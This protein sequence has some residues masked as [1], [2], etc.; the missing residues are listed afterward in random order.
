MVKVRVVVVVVAA[1]V[2]GSGV[3]ILVE[4]GAAT[5]KDGP[6]VDDARVAVWQI[7]SRHP[8][9]LIIAPLPLFSVLTDSHND[10]VRSFVLL[11]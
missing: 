9:F 6:V 1:I 7:G 3:V 2:V 10:S 11:K 4:V 5:T 8:S